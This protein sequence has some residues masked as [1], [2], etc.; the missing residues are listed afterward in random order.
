MF[1]FYWFLLSLVE[2]TLSIVAVVLSPILALPFLSTDKKS[3]W[4]RVPEGRETLRGWLHLFSTWDDGIDAGWFDGHYDTRMPT[5]TSP[6][7]AREGS[8]FERWK[9]RMAW[10]VRNSCYGFAY[11]FFSFDRTG[12]A[13]TRVVAQHGQWDSAS[14]N[15]EILTQTNLAGKKAFLVRG[16]FYIRGAWYIRVQIG[17]KLTWDTPKAQL[18]THINPLRVWKS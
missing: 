13:E 11:Y 6:A 9:L 7:K 2:L 17:W 10:I 4:C 12:G 8:V 3:D 16:Q 14:T 15:Y 18:A 5:W 1:F